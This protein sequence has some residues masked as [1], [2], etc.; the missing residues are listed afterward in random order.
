MID[1]NLNPERKDLRIFSGLLIPFFA[2][3]SF[4]AWRRGTIELETVWWIVTVAAAVGI[5]GLIWPAI[6]RWVYVVWM[7]AVFPIGWV[8]SY[9]LVGV[10]FYLVVTPIG[11]IMRLCGRDP[12]Q[13]K[14]DPQAKTYWQPRESTKSNDRYFRQF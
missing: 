1:F 3:I 7:A 4:L 5:V 13:R 10:V 14:F 11:L 9:L 6:I 2:L 12:M 8:M